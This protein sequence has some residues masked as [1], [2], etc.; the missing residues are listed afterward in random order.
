MGGGQSREQREEDQLKARGLVLVPPLFERD[1]R[2]RSRMTA[3]AYD[4]MFC[5]P[6]LKWLFNDYIRH[7]QGFS[8]VRLRWGCLPCATLE[9]QVLH[10]MMWSRFQWLDE[11][12]L[13]SNRLRHSAHSSECFGMLY[14]HFKAFSFATE[15]AL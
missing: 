1:F 4:W 12:Y 7:D 5:K 3:S 6:G 11:V 13:S 15:Q 8:I 14:S 2:G 10:Q 9:H